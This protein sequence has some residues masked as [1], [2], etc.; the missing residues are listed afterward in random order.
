MDTIIL[1]RMHVVYFTRTEFISFRQM[2]KE[3]SKPKHQDYRNF[4]GIKGAKVPSHAFLSRFRTLLGI[5][6]YK[7]NELSEP[8]LRQAEQMRGFL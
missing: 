2:C 1:F 3:F 6:D 8:L 5:S 7:L 4:L